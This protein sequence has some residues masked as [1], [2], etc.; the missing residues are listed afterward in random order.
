MYQLWTTVKKNIDSD[1]SFYSFLWIEI[2]WIVLILSTL[3]HT[4]ISV[5][6]TRNRHAHQTAPTR[7]QSACHWAAKTRKRTATATTFGPPSARSWPTTSTRQPWPPSIALSRPVH[8]AQCLTSAACPSHSPPTITSDD[9]RFT[10]EY[11]KNW[12]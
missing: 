9:V 3:V 8:P 10:L 1:Y 5:F 7:Y 6:L 11:N 12:N 4:S 2:I